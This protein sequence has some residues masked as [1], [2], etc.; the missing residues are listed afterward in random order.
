MHDG[1]ATIAQLFGGFACN[2]VGMLDAVLHE[3]VDDI[4]LTASGMPCR[5]SQP[6]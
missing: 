6:L 3:A 5:V 1:W 4:V 2:P